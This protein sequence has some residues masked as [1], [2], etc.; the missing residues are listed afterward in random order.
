MIDSKFKRRRAAPRFDSFGTNQGFQAFGENQGGGKKSFRH[1]K[2]TSLGGFDCA[3]GYLPSLDSY[4]GHGSAAVRASFRRGKTLSICFLSAPHSTRR[5]SSERLTVSSA[6]GSAGGC[7]RQRADL[8]PGWQIKIPT[9]IILLKFAVCAPPLPSFT[10]RYFLPPRTV[11]GHT[12][13]RGGGACQ[14]VLFFPPSTVHYTIHPQLSPKTAVNT[15][16]WN[17]PA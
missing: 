3:P 2:K 8:S 9:G 11:G 1:I 5:R 12:G 4:S 6:S 15:Q 10:K 17:K 14:P 16:K 13:G 7:S